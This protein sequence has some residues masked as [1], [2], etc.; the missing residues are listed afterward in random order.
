MNVG[1]AKDSLGYRVD[2][3]MKGVYKIMSSPTFTRVA[4]LKPRYAR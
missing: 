4:D 2:I 3:G 1:H